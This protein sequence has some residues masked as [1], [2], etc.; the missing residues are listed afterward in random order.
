MKE[1]KSI[2]SVC[3]NCKH[4][5][6]QQSDDQKE[7][8]GECRRYPPKVIVTPEGEVLCVLPFTEFKESCGEFQ[9]RHDA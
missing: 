4:W 6:K 2:P 9:I 7:S 8:V 1:I 3:S 5:K